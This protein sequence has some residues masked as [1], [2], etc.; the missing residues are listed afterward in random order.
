MNQGHDVA[1][2]VGEVGEGVKNFHKGDEVAALHELDSLDC[3]P[4]TP[5][6]GNT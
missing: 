6:H 5:L 1:G 2:Y 3:I 4:D